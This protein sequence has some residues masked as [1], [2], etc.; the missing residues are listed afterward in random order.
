M[1]WLPAGCSPTTGRAALAHSLIFDNQR[2]GVLLVYTPLLFATDAEAQ[3][4]FA[5]LANELGFALHKMTL[6]ARRRATE[7]E[8]KEDI[9]SAENK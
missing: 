7:Q 2:Y 5:G 1:C 4:L 6:E 3:R 8:L 9:G